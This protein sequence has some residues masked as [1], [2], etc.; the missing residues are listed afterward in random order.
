[1][2]RATFFKIENANHGEPPSVVDMAV[3]HPT[4]PTMSL[5]LSNTDDHSRIPTRGPP[6]A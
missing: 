5:A 6:A 4:A 2:V 3:Y 1:M